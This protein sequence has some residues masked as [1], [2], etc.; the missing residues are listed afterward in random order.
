MPKVNVKKRHAV[1]L[2]DAKVRVKALVDDFVKEYSSV[3][4][5]VTWSPDGTSASAKGTGFEGAFRVDG[6]QVTVDVDLSFLLSP[7]KGKVEATLHKRLDD[8]FGNA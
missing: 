1:P 2:D 7:I 4:K 6:S 8:S 5:S 3:V